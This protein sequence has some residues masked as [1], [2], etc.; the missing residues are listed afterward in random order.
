VSKDINQQKEQ[1]FTAIRDILMNIN[2]NDDDPI[3]NTG[4]ALDVLEQL[5]ARILAA[6]AFDEESL[7]ELCEESF[8][9][10]E[11]LAREFFAE[12]ETAAAE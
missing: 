9:N 5:L 6:S 11:E 12:E 3:G 10:I 8:E 1:A 2:S 4:H 7:E